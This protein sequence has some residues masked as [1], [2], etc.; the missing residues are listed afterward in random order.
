MPGRTQS[1][2]DFFA[3]PRLT[4]CFLPLLCE[5]VPDIAMPGCRM[6][7]NIVNRDVKGWLAFLYILRC[8]DWNKVRQD[9]EERVAK[10]GGT[11]CGDR[12]NVLLCEEDSARIAQIAPGIGAHGIIP[13]IQCTDNQWI[14]GRNLAAFSF[15]CPFLPRKAPVSAPACCRPRSGQSSE[16][17]TMLL[18]LCEGG[19]RRRR[20][21]RSTLFGASACFGC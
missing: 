8:T 10:A 3:R 6:G 9:S 18:F 5:K 7:E 14:E 11:C 1:Y 4:A 16:K 17:R 20:T 19:S 2:K 12:R 21:S 15:F 13:E